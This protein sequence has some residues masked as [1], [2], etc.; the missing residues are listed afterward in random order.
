MKPRL[1]DPT[2][3]LKRFIFFL[4]ALLLRKWYSTLPAIQD[5]VKRLKNVPQLHLFYITD[6][7]YCSIIS[8]MFVI[9]SW[10]SGK[11]PSQT[12]LDADFSQL[13]NDITPV[14]FAICLSH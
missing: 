7:K 4:F 8:S 3:Q 14:K 10:L 9:T 5:Q 6:E 1:S 11:E 2:F 13:L 12:Y